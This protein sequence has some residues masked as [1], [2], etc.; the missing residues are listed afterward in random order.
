MRFILDGGWELCGMECI[1][2]SLL[3]WGGWGIM[4]SWRILL[5]PSND[6]FEDGLWGDKG[7][8][9]EFHDGLFWVTCDHALKDYGESPS[10]SFEYW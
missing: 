2:M 9:D 8:N 3:V 4:C 7:Y 5:E 6:T 1:M 10:L